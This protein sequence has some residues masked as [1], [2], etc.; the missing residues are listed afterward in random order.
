MKSTNQITVVVNGEQITVFRGMRVKHALIALDQELYEAAA[1]GRL[2]VQDGEGHAVGLEGS[3]QEG[4]VL[5]TA[6]PDAG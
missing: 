2:K 1:A 4:A 6:P 5:M 3:L